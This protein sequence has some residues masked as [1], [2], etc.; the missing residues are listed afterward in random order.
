V[1]RKVERTFFKINASPLPPATFGR[2]RRFSQNRP[3]VSTVL[4]PPIRQGDKFVVII[5]A[6]IITERA[7]FVVN[8]VVYA[9][10]Y[11]RYTRTTRR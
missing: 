6:T 5:I 8:I 3:A 10:R 7:T 11:Y 2:F 9:L 4:R 1:S